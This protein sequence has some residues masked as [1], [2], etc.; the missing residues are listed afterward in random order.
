MSS[1]RKLDLSENRVRRAD[2]L[3][4][5]LMNLHSDTLQHLHLVGVFTFKAHQNSAG[6]NEEPRRVAIVIAAFLRGCARARIV[7]LL[8]GQAFVEQA[9]IDSYNASGP[10]PCGCSALMTL[11]L[12]RNF[13]RS[14]EIC[15]IQ[16]TWR[17]SGSYF[18]DHPNPLLARALPSTFGLDLIDSRTAQSKA[19]S[20][21]ELSAV[22]KLAAKIGDALDSSPKYDA[23][24][25]G[26]L[27]DLSMQKLVQPASTAAD[28]RAFCA[29]V[30]SLFKRASIRGES[31]FGMGDFRS[32]G[33]DIELLALRGP[34]RSQRK[35]AYHLL[36]AT[37]VLAC[38]ARANK[39]N[40]TGWFSLP[41]DLRRAC[42]ESIPT[43]FIPS[44][45][46]IMTFLEIVSC[47]PTPAYL[48]WLQ[49]HSVLSHRIISRIFSYAADSRTIGYA[50]LPEATLLP[51]RI[52]SDRTAR[53]ND[54]RVLNEAPWSFA[55]AQRRWSPLDRQPSSEAEFHENDCVLSWEQAAYLRTI[56]F[57]EEIR[58][59]MPRAD[60]VTGAYM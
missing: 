30:A 39:P 57:P 19:P 14:G 29:I 53:Q 45:G 58:E 9:L 10:P 42:L 13:L 50:L 28:Y 26:V 38:R 52:A 21:S 22:F 36:A 32:T 55:A 20:L 49:Q 4:S 47:H 33:L 37:R 35:A 41:A 3:A 5:L 15:L 7:R 31:D 51:L 60:E 48:E 2:V 24:V 44:W 59:L 27:S 8:L 17:L 1:L 56:G 6:S 40:K 34:V 46:D 43:L 18:D 12:K 54:V 23:T 16:G 25:Q 11:N